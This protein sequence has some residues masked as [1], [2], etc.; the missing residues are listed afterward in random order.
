MLQALCPQWCRSVQR[1][2][3]PKANFY[4]DFRRLAL[5]AYYTSEAGATQALHYEVIPEQYQGCNISAAKEPKQPWSD[6]ST[7]DAIVVGSGITGGWAA[8]ELTEKGLK[9]LV[10]EAGRPIV[11]EERL[12]RAHSSVGNE[13]S[14]HGRSRTAAQDSPSR[15]RA[16]PVMSGRRN[17]SSATKKIPTP[18]LPTSPSAGFAAARSAADPSCGAVKATA[19]AIWTSK[20]TLREGIAVDWPIRYADIEPWYD[21]VEDF[22]G[23]SGEALGLPQLPDS[24]FLPPMEMNCAEAWSRTRI[25]KN[26][27]DERVLTIG[28][29]RHA[30][31]RLTWPRRLPL[32]RPLRTR[33]HHPVLFQQPQRDASGR[34]KNRAH[35]AAPYSVVHSVIFDPAYAQGTGVRVIDAPDQQPLE[36]HS[37]VIFLCASALESVAHPAQ[38]CH[39]GIS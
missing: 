22:A 13:V 21:Y 14:R 35:D 29:V 27:G 5:T 30:D 9:T 1:P 28:R 39:S 36:F 38:L 2:A 17:F 7:Y 4:A 25:A 37:A 19:G 32:L 24:K 16:T 26:F 8:K 20:P 6:Q 33:M 12:R 18:P 15:A 31:A 3:P 23:I 34:R 10:L 11:P